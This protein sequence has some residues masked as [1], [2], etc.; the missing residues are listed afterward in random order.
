MTRLFILLLLFSMQINAK[1]KD[2]SLF[3][4]ISP[5]NE[6]NL[7]SS[8]LIHQKQLN[9]TA[10]GNGEIS[11]NIFDS[12]TN[13]FVSDDYRARISLVRRDNSSSEWVYENGGPISGHLFQ[14]KDLPDGEYY[15]SITND[16]LYDDTIEGPIYVPT[17]WDPQGQIIN[18]SS[19][20][21]TD[22]ILIVNSENTVLNVDFKLVP[23]AFLTITNNEFNGE[24]LS[25]GTAVNSDN[26]IFNFS[27]SELNT[28]V[29]QVSVRNTILYSLLPVGDYRFNVIA[30]D[31]IYFDLVHV[32]Q[33]YGEGE[34]YS[35]QLEL[36]SGKGQVVSLS[37]FER[38][39]I[40]VNLSDGASI[41]GKLTLEDNNPDSPVNASI[42]VFNKN[43]E[44]IGDTRTDTEVSPEGDFK[45]SGLSAGEYHLI[46]AT[47]GY[48]LES[49]NN[50][51]CPYLVCDNYDSIPVRITRNEQHTGIKHT[52]KKGHKLSGKILDAETGLE[53]ESN[54]SIFN[55]NNY[56]EVL[57]EN[58][59]LV[60]DVYINNN[61]GGDYSYIGGI[62]Y[63][64]YYIKTGSSKTY[65]SNRNYVN[66]VYPN[67]ECEGNIC[68]FSQAEL[69]TLGSANSQQQFNFNLNKGY[70]VS[71]TVK[72]TSDNLS[73]QNIQVA[74]LNA[75]GV[76]ANI[77]TTDINGDYKLGSLKPGSYFVRTYNGNRKDYRLFIKTGLIPSSLVNQS[78]PNHTCMNNVC[79]MG[80]ENLIHIVDE[81]LT[82]I[83][84]EL[85][86]GLSMSGFIKDKNENTGIA[87]IE[88]K[89]YSDTGDY[90]ESYYTDEFGYF[91]TAALATGNYK[92]VT[93]NP[94][95]YI[96]QAYGGVECGMGE[97]DSTLSDTITIL[98]SSVENI[99]FELKSGENYYP[100]LSGLWYNKNQSGHGLQLEVIKSNGSAILYAS[101]YVVKDGEP[102]WLTG[103]G[104][105]NKDLAF[106]DLSITNGNAFPPAYNPDTIE[107]QPWGTLRF[108][109]SD[110]NHAQMNWSTDVDGFSNGSIDLTRLTTLASVQKSDDSIDACLS[111]TFYN[112]DQSGHG[113]M[114]EVLDEN[115][116]SLALTWFTH[117]NNKQFWLLATGTVNGS[118]AN[119]SA[120]YKK[121]SDFPPNFDSSQSVT[122]EWGS[123]QLT[124]VDNDHVKLDWTPNS[125][126]SNFGSGSINLQRL[127][128][129][130]SIGCD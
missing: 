42:I 23:A 84:F 52:M 63:G 61:Y 71:G 106:V 94:M 113:V 16:I 62:P 70:S 20:I 111:G 50:K 38:K 112:S 28:L 12:E 45:V 109:F 115:A 7:S 29:G 41:S 79:P 99:D 103:T 21:T 5:L 64:Q 66:Q 122:V 93:G 91:K 83:D 108:E 69:V 77:I 102:I 129:I 47:S 121:G 24:S 100:E 74:V 95:H 72:N 40:D 27:R 98:D 90:I 33:I 67:I 80:T 43:G 120:V 22:S 88:I 4:N 78:Y 105:L 128:K 101:W 57:D 126:H 59:N 92:V 31:K 2:I 76:I 68:D 18:S 34:C 124:K 116:E 17:L 85:E 89:L 86:Q 130:E 10:T 82:G 1:T 44:V 97:C 13:E 54:P 3:E 123:F 11:G 36:L 125:E 6:F 75:Q 26:E 35:C 73:E 37:K 32:N 39:T 49:Y 81:N 46:F 8:S 104:P 110:M 117:Y 14:F 53:L 96:N 9:D 60:A 87:E 15:L 55:I 65:T 58:L 107:I 119:L 127:S 30:K 48:I 19:F 56:I 51:V 118:T 114:I 25:N